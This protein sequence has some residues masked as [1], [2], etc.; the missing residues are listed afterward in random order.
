METSIMKKFIFIVTV[1][2]SSI[3]LNSCKQ[4]LLD[5]N[6]HGSVDPEIYYPNATDDQAL[7]LSAAIYSQVYNNTFWNGFFNGMADDGLSTG[8]TFSNINVNSQNHGGI[9]YFTTLYRINYLC[10][11]IIEKLPANTDIK[12]QVIGEAYFW[13][14]WAYVYL[15]R[16]FGTPPLVNHVLSISELQPANGTPAELWSFVESSLN[17]AI[18][19][20]P[21]K[22]A[23]GQQR[24]IGGRVTKHSAYSL[25]GKAQLIEGHY[26]D[27]ITNLEV[28]LNSGKYKLIDDY[29]NLYHLPADFCDEYMW[30][31]NMDD[32]DQANFINEGDNR[33]VNLT[34]RT[35]NVTVPGGLTVQGYGGADFNKN[36]YDFMVARGEKGLPRQLGTI[37]SYEDI[38]A[39]FVS[40]GLA[41]DTAQAKK[42]FWGTAPVMANCQGYFRSKMLPWANELYQYDDVRVIHSKINWPG[43]RYAEVELLYAEACIQSGTKLAQ[44]LAA[45]NDVRHRAGLADLVGSFTLAD[46]KDEKRAE[47]AYENERYFDLIRWGDDAAIATVLATRG[48]NVYNFSGYLGGTTTYNITTTPVQGAQTF[49][50]NRDKL[51]PFPYTEGLLNPNLIQNPNW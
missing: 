50:T 2:F 12:K 1:L 6:Q 31:W 38:L 43:M 34:W 24:A 5:I 7:Q 49:Q 13:R 30:E 51:F 25:L 48:F 22:A 21:E 40:L 35:E 9:G 46:L 20:L 15:I 19:R 23:L 33:A 17:E 28:V 36:F 32:A 47:L 16:M 14:A 41:T 29:R 8:G 39:R 26:T 18:T 4:D 37:W 42:K 11:M 45:L 10:N 3:L 44:G 27:A